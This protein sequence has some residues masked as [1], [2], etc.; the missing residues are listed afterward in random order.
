[1]SSLIFY[2]DKD[3][4][5]VATDTL[6][7]TPNG[8]PAFFT[9]KAFAVPHLQMIMAST[10]FSGFLGKWFVEVNDRMVVRGIDSLDYHAPIVLASL[11][12]KFCEENSIPNNRTS[13]VYHFGFSEEDGLIR[14]YVYRSGKNF[15]SE[16]LEYGLGVKPECK[17]PEGAITTDVIKKMMEE[18]ISIQ[19]SQ[20]KDKRVYIGGKIQI[21]HLTKTSCSISTLDQFDD[22]EAVEQRIFVNY[23]L[24]KKDSY[25]K[26]EAYKKT[27]ANTARTG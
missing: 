3:Q 22:F 20:P 12:N 15:S 14:T 10:G 6:A 9:T 13:T 4:A 21:H 27:R 11:W 7:T 18:Q 17:I 19:E 16:I 24:G 23:D 26:H 1:M 5:L 8:E 2:T 25:Q